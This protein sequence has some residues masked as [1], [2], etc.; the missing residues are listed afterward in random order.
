[1][2]RCFGRFKKACWASGGCYL[3]PRPIDQHIKGFGFGAK[4]TNEQGAIYIR[5]E[6][7]IALEFI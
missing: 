4:V 3:G 1:M 5:A 7:L 6:E 2:G